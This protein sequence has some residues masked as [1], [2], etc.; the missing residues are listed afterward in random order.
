[1]STNEVEKNSYELL[2]VG[3]E[4]AEQEIK[5]QITQLWKF[6]ELNQVYELLL[7]PLRRLALISSVRAKEARKDRFSN[8]DRKRKNL[9]K[10]LEQRER[11]FKKQKLVKAKEA[12]DRENSIGW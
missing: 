5:T 11:A 12:R 7:D 3:L 1:M 8:Y 2:N 9:Q 4:S 10:E 6:H